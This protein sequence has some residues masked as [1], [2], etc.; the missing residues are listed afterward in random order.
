MKRTLTLVLAVAA[1]GI[2]AT[3]GSATRAEWSPPRDEGV[4]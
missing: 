2:V 1:A 4:L 3:A